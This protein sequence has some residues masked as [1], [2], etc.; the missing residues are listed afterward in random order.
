MSAKV[1]SQMVLWIRRVIGKAPPD[2]SP[3]ASGIIEKIEKVI[4]N[5]LQY[6][7]ETE[8]EGPDGIIHRHRL[9]THTEQGVK[10]SVTVGGLGN[11]SVTL[12][13]QNQKLIRQIARHYCYTNKSAAVS[14]VVIV[15]TCREFTVTGV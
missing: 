4:A 8:L 13:G 11:P 1:L 12:S 7:K 3:E 9:I 10:Y 14:T 5:V 2:L 15:E 6:Y